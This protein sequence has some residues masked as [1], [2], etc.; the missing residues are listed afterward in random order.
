MAD[1]TRVAVIGYGLAGSAFH[2]P[3]VDAVDGLRVT[4][5][6]TGDPERA[7]TARDRHP[8]VVVHPSV[9]ELWRHADDVDLV[10][11]ASPNR[12]HVEQA[13]AALEVGLHVVVDK[14]V[15]ATA[16]GVRALGELAKQTGKVLTA[17][18]NRR[19]DGDF[20][21]VRKL[22]ED[23]TL[24]Q[25]GRF[26]SRFERGAK[27]V[28]SA[29]RASPDPADMA[30]ILYDLGTHLADQAIVLFGRPVTVY[31]ETRAPRP[32]VRVAEDATIL[33]THEGGVRSYLRA[34]NVTMPVTPRFAVAGGTAGYRCWGLDPQE[35][36]S[37]AGTPPTA[38]GFGVYGEDRWGTLTT[39]DGETVVPTVD[40][41]YL[42]FYRGVRDCVRGD[43]P[44]PVAVAE[45]IALTETIEAAIRSAASGKPVAL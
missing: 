20:L 12:F 39:P 14:P 16:R 22:V 1:E 41:D 23:G 10:V 43:G 35:A 7:A 18:Q 38:E 24:G 44:P 9:D 6:V 36:A 29:W 4:A 5:V 11:V 8:D 15:A 31:A 28:R 40:G 26:E 37:R 30:N 13:T 21:T 19:W 17:F 25:V 32:E 2:A 34:S 45:S 3:F 33:L 42:A 27:A